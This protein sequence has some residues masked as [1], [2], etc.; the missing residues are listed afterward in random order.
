MWLAGWNMPG[1]LPEFPP[2]R[3]NDWQ[4]A[5]EFIH[6]AL[7][8]VAEDD[9]SIVPSRESTDARIAALQLER[10]AT[11]NEPWISGQVGM[12]RYWIEKGDARGYCENS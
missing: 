5:K 8:V 12:Y 10:Q 2:E 7:M 1:Y 4:E 3:F 9:L 11:V 6:G